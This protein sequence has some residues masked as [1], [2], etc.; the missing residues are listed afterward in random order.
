MELLWVSSSQ[1]RKSSGVVAII[2]GLLL[3][4]FSPN[5]PG[6]I[7][8]LLSSV[9]FVFSLI[10]LITGMNVKKTVV[11]LPMISL[12]IIGGLLGMTA[13]LA[14]D[15]AVSFMGVILGIGV[16]VLGII[17]LAFLSAFASH[18]VSHKLLLI[19]GII[20]VIIGVFLLFSPQEGLR[21]VIVFFGGYFIVYG[22]IRLLGRSPF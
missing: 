3:L 11:A 14:P 10:I 16:I 8:L 19:A 2:I 4:I 22:C 20:T 13:L 15:L 1:T 12:G 6:F 17:Q 21:W 18:Q 5:I 7:G 9:I